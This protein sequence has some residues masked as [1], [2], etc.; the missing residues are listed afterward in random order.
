[1]RILPLA[2]MNL[3]QATEAPWEFVYSL[4]LFLPQ[5][6]FFPLL[7]TLKGR[8]LCYCPRAQLTQGTAHPTSTEPS[9]QR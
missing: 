4:P 2:A 1:M 8:Q 5:T 6:V 7:T 9:E 3:C